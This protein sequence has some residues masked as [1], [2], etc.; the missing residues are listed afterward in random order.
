MVASKE[1]DIIDDSSEVFAGENLIDLV[2]KMV[3]LGYGGME[4]LAGVPGTLGG[5]IVMNAGAYGQEIKEVLKS[6][7]SLTEDG[8]LKDYSVEELELGYRTSIFKSNNEI[9]VSAT[10]DLLSDEKD[11]LKKRMSE[12][13]KKRKEKQPLNFPSC[14]SVFKRPEGNYAGT[15]IEQAGLKGFSIGGAKVSEKHAN[16]IVNTG[17]A[18]SA[19]VKDLIN[20][21]QN[22]VKDKSG[23]FL[24]RE[25]LY[26]G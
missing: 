12:C 23:I 11:L 22:V 20:H 6:V 19:D 3:N 26:I 16:F 2:R 7:K 8:Q 18:T 9:V 13:L 1:I 21:I 14:G 24:E 5:A 17:K 10:F 4:C 25:V 15:L